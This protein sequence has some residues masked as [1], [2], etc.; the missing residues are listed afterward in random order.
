M[1]TDVLIVLLSATQEVEQKG[2][3][4]L[5]AMK[6]QGMPTLCLNVVQG[7]ENVGE[8]DEQS[9]ILVF[10]SYCISILIYL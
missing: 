3:D 9:V 6:N 2:I 7:I 5:F 8:Q 10:S 4:V 1:T